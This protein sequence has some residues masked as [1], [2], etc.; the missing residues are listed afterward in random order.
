M[1]PKA[2]LHVHLEGTIRPE[3]AK[4][5]ALRNH[6]NFPNHLLDHSQFFY[7]SNGFMDFL[8]AYDELAAL[9][10]Q[11]QDYFD[12][13]YDYLKQSALK[14]VIYCEMMYSPDHAEK[15]SQIPSREHL[16]AIGE[17]ILKAQNDYGIIGRIITTAVRHFGVEACEK[18]ALHAKLEPFSFVSGF[19]LGGDELGFPPQLFKKTYD[20][21][22]DAG[23]KTTVHAGEWGNAQ[24]MKTAINICQVDRIGHGVRAIEDENILSMLKDLQIPLEIC[25]TSNVVLGIYPRIEDH[26]FPLFMAQG[27]MVSIN[28]DDPPFMSTTIDKEYDLVQKTFQYSDETMKAIS[29]QAIE[30]AFIDKDLK[31]ELL[32]KI[33]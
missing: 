13:T 15:V 7:R 26:P 25:P 21:A 18:V 28:S 17:A 2:E 20:M 1:I 11:P 12:I 27:I 31:T 24:S 3:I 29:R 8:K 5:L 30:V 14:G 9:I 6:L 22:R 4:N 19:G 16:I 33:I 32:K 23:L 10:R